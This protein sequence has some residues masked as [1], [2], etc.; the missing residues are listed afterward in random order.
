M[1]EPVPSFAPRMADRVCI[2]TGASSG[3]GRAAA[4]LL[5]AHGAQVVLADVTTEPIVDA[6]PRSALGKVLKARLRAQ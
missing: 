2:V 3:I 1:S 6:M 5:A 4:R